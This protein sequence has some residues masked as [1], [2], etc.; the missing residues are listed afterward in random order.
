MFG[1]RVAEPASSQSEEGKLQSLCLRERGS[2]WE[3]GSLQPPAGTPS[4]NRGHANEVGGCIMVVMA[5]GG[6]YRRS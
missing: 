2:Q 4:V 6:K 1:I 3:R 5:R